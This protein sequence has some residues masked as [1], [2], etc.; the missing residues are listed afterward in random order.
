M[1]RPGDPGASGGGEM[2]VDPPRRT[3][4]SSVYIP[5]GRAPVVW[6]PATLWAA[7]VRYGIMHGMVPASV[8]ARIMPEAPVSISPSTPASYEAAPP[9]PAPVSISPS[10]PLST[11]QNVVISMKPATPPPSPTPSPAPTP[12]PVPTPVEAAPPTAAAAPV[13]VAPRAGMGVHPV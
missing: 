5:L 2:S 11:T 9:A 12:A 7:I 8:A 3:L 4:L 6:R 13:H 10:T 1:P